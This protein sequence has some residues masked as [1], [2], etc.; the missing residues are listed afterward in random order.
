MKNI[1]HFSSLAYLAQPRQYSYA[2]TKAAGVF[3]A[4][5]MSVLIAAP[6]LPGRRSDAEAEVA[7]ALAL[8]PSR[9]SQRQKGQSGGL[10]RRTQRR[11][12]SASTG[13]T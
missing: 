13:V 1:C 8:A 6:L 2:G 7:T 10:M 5:Q 9:L 11:A 12:G 3:H 4:P